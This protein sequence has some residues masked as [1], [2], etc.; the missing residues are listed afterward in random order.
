MMVPRASKTTALYEKILRRLQAGRFV[1]GARI[2]PRALADEF[3]TSP[4]PVVNALY[5]LLGEGMLTN[6]AREGGFQVPPTNERRLRNLYHWMQRLMVMACDIGITTDDELPDTFQPPNQDSDIV[7]LT[8][9]L[10]EEVA[11][12]TDDYCLHDA[13]RH[14]NNRLEPIRRVTQPLLLDATGE[15]AQLRRLWHRRDLGHLRAA[16]IRYHERRMRMVPRIVGLLDDLEFR[17]HD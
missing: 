13:V 5:R 11:L 3:A 10:F 2:D 9:E 8:R 14:T 6:H 4:T 17:V 1:P 7:Q 16:L 15:F 12:A